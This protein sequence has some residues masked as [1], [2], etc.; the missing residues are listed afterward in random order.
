MKSTLFFPILLLPLGLFG[1]STPSSTDYTEAD[2]NM[3]NPNRMLLRTKS[4]GAYGTKGSPYVF[5]DF[6]KG[7][8]YYNNQQRVSSILL[9]YDCH[10]NQLVYTTGGATYLLNKDQID[11]FEA[12]AGG[13]TVM[14]FNQVFVEKLKKR[15]FMRVLYN[16]KSI[17]YKHYYKDFKEADYGGAYS[18]DRR[19]D[20][21][22]DREAYYIKTSEK[23]LR[24]IKPRKKSLLEVMTDKSGELEKYFKQE[25]PDLKTDDGLVQ[26]I[27][28]YDSIE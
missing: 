4:A 12:F 13:D 23:D 26:V 5:N 1:Q 8:L 14:L 7:N 24:F 6:K 22:H 20:E 15:I 19:Y 28:F 18:Q 27:R 11:F 25:K 21:Y 9:N 2:M 3:L 10:N 17:L 16:E